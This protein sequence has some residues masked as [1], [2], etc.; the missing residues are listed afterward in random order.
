MPM[1]SSALESKL[2]CRLWRSFEAALKPTVACESKNKLTIRQQ[3]I[4]FNKDMGV[5][6]DVMSNKNSHGI[7]PCK[8]I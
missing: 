6:A 1:N 8:N 7:L 2:I 3:Q 5:R 4:I